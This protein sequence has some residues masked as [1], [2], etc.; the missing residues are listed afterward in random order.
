[1]ASNPVSPVI[2]SSS[3]SLLYTHTHTHTHTHTCR[4]T[5]VFSGFSHRGILD[6]RMWST[7]WR[8][9]IW[10]EHRDYRNANARSP[11]EC[12]IINNEAFPVICWHHQEM[13]LVSRKLIV[14]PPLEIQ[15]LLFFFFCIFFIGVQ[16]ANI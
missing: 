6:A 2:W 4:G 3:L 15:I 7:H 10:P 12:D 1:M 14:T 9:N 8:E 13:N 11:K 16:F 5:Q